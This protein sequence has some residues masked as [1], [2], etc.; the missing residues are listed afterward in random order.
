LQ[1]HPNAAATRAAQEATMSDQTPQ[2]YV[3][4]FMDKVTH[5]YQPAGEYFKGLYQP[6]VDVDGSQCTWPITGRIE[7]EDYVRGSRVPEANPANTNVTAIMGDRQVAEWIYK[8]DISKIKYSERDVAAKRIAM[9]KGRRNDLIVVNELNAAATALVD[10]SGTAF[11]LIH[12]LTAQVTLSDNN[13]IYQP[14]DV[15]CGMPGLVFQQFNTFKQ[16]NSADWVGAD[17]LPYKTHEGGGGPGV[18]GKVWNGIFCFE[19]PKEYCPIPSANNFDFFLYHKDAIGYHS[20]HDELM[21]TYENPYTAFLHNAL[22]SNAAKTLLPA[23][24][25]RI[26]CASNG[27][28]TLN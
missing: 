18:R 23:G 19:I 9:A 28:I 13:V 27:A 12:L 8:S 24:I 26:R 20:A 22:W 14:G 25:V 2:H 21:V 5:V 15:V 11:S 17:G 16:V 3:T 10:A 1:L 6:P 4:Q 7:A